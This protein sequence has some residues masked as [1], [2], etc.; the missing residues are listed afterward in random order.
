MWDI[1]EIG[2]W[3]TISASPNVMEL[4]KTYSTNSMR[5]SS[6]RVAMNGGM[7]NSLLGAVGEPGFLGD[8]CVFVCVVGDYCV[9]V[10]VCY[11]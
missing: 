8:Y 9:C 3:A 11:W 4:K 6:S 2:T 1:N 10:C 5:S 7:E